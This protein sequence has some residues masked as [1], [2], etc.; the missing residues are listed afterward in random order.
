[1]QLSPSN[2]IRHRLTLAGYSSY[3][4]GV[5]RQL[6]LYRVSPLLEQLASRSWEL[7]PVSV[8]RTSKAYFLPGQMDR[9]LGTAYTDDPHAEVQ[10]GQGIQHAA[11]RALLLKNVWLIDHSFY[12]GRW[13]LDI[14]PRQRLSR[15][16]KFMPRI[17]VDTEVDR[18]SIYSTFA[19]NEFFGMW[20]TDDCPSYP[21]ALK[22]GMPVAIDW[23]YSHQ[24]EF[25]SLLGMN[26][27]RPGGAFLRE[28]VIIDDGWSFGNGKH[29][30][31][32]AMRRH[33]LS[34]FGQESHPGAFI[35][36]RDTGQTRV[37]INELEVAEYLQKKRGF[38]IVDPERQS[39]AEILSMCAGARVLMG[40]EG[41]Q[42]ANGMVVLDEGASMLVLQPPSR[43]CC[44]LKKVTDM[45]GQNFAFVVG[46][47]TANGFQVNPQEIERTLDLLPNC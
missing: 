34:R 37:M 7:E 25:E 36:R 33:L 12:Q 15:R 17:H 16:Q 3:A 1:M 8:S 5:R 47:P 20:L 42:L 14:G 35:L 21:L 6:Q 40:V 46:T 43:F 32:C 41:S 19:G 11:T 30:R 23:Q 29:K 22:E 39:A 44:A 9:I 10:G 27:V 38:R 2:R 26:P 28:A 4:V 31:F 24:A 45:E 13:R 18:A